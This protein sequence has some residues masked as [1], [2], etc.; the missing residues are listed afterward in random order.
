M[1]KLMFSIALFALL[2]GCSANGGDPDNTG[3]SPVASPVPTND[4]DNQ[5][6]QGGDEQN[7]DHAAA[8][9]QEAADAV[10]RALKDKDLTKLAAV[11]HP[12]KGLLFSPYAHIDQATA[13]VFQKDELPDLTDATVRTWGVHDGSGDPIELTFA[14]YYDKFVYDKPFIDAESVG[15]DEILGHGNTIVNIDEV[16]PNSYIVDY[17]FS[18][19]DK[20]YEGMDWESLIL[21]LEQHEGFWYVS[22]VVHSQ[23]TI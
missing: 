22:A 1:K 20:Q 10:I 23:W 12:E 21:V 9:S 18:G 4:N 7:G 15:Q 2:I 3:G 14:Q 19:F 16:F 8:T 5:A 6:N 13:L 11:I 17:H